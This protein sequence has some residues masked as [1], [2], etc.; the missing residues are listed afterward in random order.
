V[1]DI[2]PMAGDEITDDDRGGV[3]H[4]GLA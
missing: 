2:V 4:R 3:R 1:A